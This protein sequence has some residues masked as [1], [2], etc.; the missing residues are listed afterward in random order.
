MDKA[1]AAD[2]VDLGS[3]TA[4]VKPKLEKSLYLHSAS[5][6]NISNKV[7]KCEAFTAYGRQVGKRQPFLQK[8]TIFS[9][10]V[11]NLVNKNAITSNLRK[12]L[13]K[14]VAWSVSKC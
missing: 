2:T 1:F 9:L 13:S 14:C 11:Y 7:G 3:I 10:S 5:R 8:S 12:K 6:L 4:L